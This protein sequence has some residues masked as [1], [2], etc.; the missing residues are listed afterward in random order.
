MASLINASTTG[1]GG[2]ITTG[3]NSGSL[4]LQTGGT[5]ALTIDTSQNVSINPGSLL[6]NGASAATTDSKINTQIT[7][8]GS[9]LTLAEFRNLDYTSGTRSFIRVR[10]AVSS[11]SSG[12]AYFGQGQDNK[13]YLIAN[14]SARGGDLVIDGGTGYVGLGTSSPLTPLQVAVTRTSSTNATSITL[15]DNVTGIQT[16]GLYKSIR[17]TSNG[18]SSISEIRFL[19]TDGTNNNTS[20]GFA[21]APTAGTLLERMRIN[22]NGYVTKPYQPAFC[23]FLNT[24]SSAS[25]GISAIPLNTVAYDTTNSFNTSTNRYTIPIAGYYLFSANIVLEYGSANETYVSAEIWVNGVRT[26]GSGW[27][28][29]YWPSS[30][31]ANSTGTHIVYLNA[32]DYVQLGTELST[33]C[34]IYGGSQQASGFNYAATKLYGYLLG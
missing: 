18:G 5:T 26:T 20:I 15:S 17:S 4:A 19:E 28:H 34:T 29:K 11:G 24:N 27:A 21:T 14:N 25:S 22:Q 7:T 10:N 32:G 30:S 2:I 12:S 31:Y 1:L 23:A 3:D 33:A 16:N 13:L 8:A 9:F 6:L